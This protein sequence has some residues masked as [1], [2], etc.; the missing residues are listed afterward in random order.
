MPESRSVAV[1]IPDPLLMAID[2]RVGVDGKNRSEV[3]IA[4]L[5]KGLAIAR[6]HRCRP[7]P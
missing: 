1:R 5:Q 4:L 7:N 3:I 6:S 2:T